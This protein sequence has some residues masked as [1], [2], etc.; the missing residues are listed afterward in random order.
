[1]QN[2]KIQTYLTSIVSA[3]LSESLNA[4]IEVEVVS[5]TFI[6]RLQLKNLYIEDQ[7]GDTLLFAGKTK[8]T[9]KSY[10]RKKKEIVISRLSMEE[11]Y[12]HFIVDTSGLLNAKFILD[13]FKGNEKKDST[14]S[15]LQ[16]KN[17][18]M[19][20]SRFHY[21]RKGRV[22]TEQ[23]V[24]FANM[25]MQH[26][27]FV[28]ESFKVEKDTISFDIR[29]M[30]L[31]EKSGFTVSELNAE[32]S[33]STH[34]M[35]FRKMDL[36]TPNSS[37]SS[38]YLNLSFFDYT[39]FSDFV[40]LIGINVNFHPSLLSFNDI[41]FF[42]PKLTGYDEE[43]R[44][45]GKLSG[46][47]S[48]LKGTNL[49]LSYRDNTKLY[50]SFSMI[51]LPDLK[52]TFLNYDITGLETNS[53]D[54][55]NLKIPG[56]NNGIH[57]KI[58][59]TI[60]ELG[61]I[62][63]SGKFTGYLDDFV[64]YGRF[65]T[66][67]GEFSSDI[68]LKPDSA[69]TLYFQ[70]KLKTRDFFLGKL[71]KQDS[72]VGRI[73]MSA[74]I[75]GY[76]SKRGLLAKMDGII[77]SLE[78]NDYNYK[79]IE[80]TGTLTDK[81]FDGSFSISDPN[82]MMDFLGKVNFSNE[83]P[84]FAFTANVSRARPYYLNL[85]KTDPAYFASF[86]LETNFTGKTID[87]LNGE[88]RIVNSLFRNKDS[89]IQ[90]YNF[91]LLAINNPDSNRIL[92]RSDVIDGE[93]KG[94]YKFST[95]V[96]SFKNL[97]GY[98]LP[99]LYVSEN[100]IIPIIDNNSFDFDITLKNIHPIVTY[101][102]P[103]MDLG[104]NTDISG[105]YRPG[106]KEIELKV[107]TSLFAYKGNE[108]RDL[109]LKTISDFQ[110]V[111]MHTSC[112]A[113]VM[114]NK[115]TV[116]SLSFISF[117]QKDTA[118]IIIDW[119]SNEGSAYK[120]KISG[121][122]NLD[123]NS[124]TNNP[125]I[126]IY[127]DPSEIYLNDTIWY[128]SECSALLD[129]SSIAIDT[130]DIR[131]RNQN[132]KINGILSENP[133]DAIRF[134]FKDMDMSALNGL[135]KKLKFHF[136]GRLSGQA[137]IKDPFH[138]MSF[139]SDLQME[140]LII[141][142]EDLGKGELVAVWNNN[143]KKIHISA[144]LGRGIIPGLKIEG[145]FVP[146]SKILDFKIDLDKLKIN[147]FQPYADILVSDIKGIATGV[148][149][150]K[151]TADKPDLSGNLRLM[152]TSFLVNY[153]QTRYNFSN[154]VQISHNNIIF[155]DTEI[156]DEKGNRAVVTGNVS[157]RYFKEYFLDVR[158]DAK[159]FAFLNTSEK[160]NPL[161]YGRIFAGGIVRIN[162][163][164]DNLQ[165]NITARSE[166]N[167]VFYIPLYA[168]E[169]VSVSNFIDWVDPTSLETGT[170]KDQTE[171]EVKMKGLNM[172]F[173]LEVTPDAEVQLIFDPK[174]GDIIKGR[175]NGNL[176]ILINS[177]GKF[178]IY[179]DIDIEEGDYLFTLKNVINKKFVV[180]KGG[181]I[182]W[183]GDPSDANIDLK[184][185]YSL[186]TTISALDPNP[187]QQTSRKRVPVDCMINMSGKLMNPTIK[188]GIE[189]P[190]AD[191]Q[192]QNIVRNSI[193]TDEELM[194][195]FVS[196]LVMN[197]FYSQQGFAQG[198]TGG[199]SSSVGKVTTTELLSNQVSSWLSQISNDFDIGVNYRPG[200][201]ISSD[202]LQVALS[203]QILNDRISI[204]G[205]LDVGGN[206]T[207]TS[208][209]TNTT[210]IV[211]DFDINFKI[212]EKLHIKAFNRANDNLLF[213]TSPYT[214]GVGFF[215][216]E[217]FNRPK[218]LFSWMKKPDSQKSPVKKE[219]ELIEEKDETLEK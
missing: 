154:D 136:A 126:G 121:I 200:D 28:L 1:M 61:T 219:E 11:S 110:K 86:L 172:S 5:L 174:I 191:Q 97:A 184:A 60:A 158:I 96:S 62:W 201:Q 95:L 37:L 173:N 187:D 50:A 99:S 119:H 111:S 145:D 146:K 43:F 102:V 113:F 209:A 35:H 87:Q 186:K 27:N 168:T 142:G 38:E 24:D 51:G 34:H 122:I 57:L 101:F 176:K 165:M 26:L 141:N 181:R 66:S 91:S 183:N 213:Q 190:G 10:S 143:N 117:I 156:F 155:K 166:R 85:E 13:E 92:I 149:T 56:G 36:K 93:V 29:N 94:R 128:I 30:S 98:Y 20:D 63:Y 21:T 138:N 116:D 129:S 137:S 218:D 17:V 22:E 72:L 84:E 210:N 67:L 195:Q 163:P 68:L 178:E 194:R 9:L 215:Y 164:T 199:T 107:L 89:Q 104:N 4:K 159:N 106:N 124:I 134:G 52:S 73:T 49:I 189:L 192:T 196:L 144:F 169:E 44:L 40:N 6:N 198:G 58:P 105:H 204:S 23:G 175:G 64:A 82:I 131:N 157:T 127:L 41:S 32:M 90:M 206:E 193:N 207:G 31:I 100:E 202:E 205:N 130:F 216:R 180:E 152:K 55:Q 54:L 133:D 132:L 140:G 167:S 79:N 115:M 170:Y 208:A 80:L 3:R 123:R 114:S 45:S 185:K 109:N 103:E 47:I 18:Q 59:R 139:L 81:I 212:T 203:T 179:G 150:L 78:L 162:G 2:S 33:I 48:N 108:W 25:D 188:P 53:G 65:S 197:N 15:I 19:K 16:I 75:N 69:N 118:S 76:T 148:L 161:F 147:M 217:Y 177:L 160:D 46:Q 39:D 135:N 8:L 120:G 71:I 125:V 42:A 153:L 88:I 70:G 83:N 214:Q 74:N 7:N 211:G 14:K 151:G 182:S 112:K 171:Y 12:V 77:D